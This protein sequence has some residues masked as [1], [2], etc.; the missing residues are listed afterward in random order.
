VVTSPRGLWKSQS[1]VRSREGSGSPSTVILSSCPTL[2]AGE[3]RVSP[4]R[5]TAALGDHGLRVAAGCDARPGDH[6]GDALLGRL[7]G[8]RAQRRRLGCS[9]RGGRA[10]RSSR[11]SKRGV[12]GRSSRPPARSAPKRPGGLPRSPWAA[13]RLVREVRATGGARA[14]AAGA[15][16]APVIA[17][18][19]ARLIAEPRWQS[20]DRIRRPG[21]HRPDGARTR[22]GPPC[23]FRR[24]S[25]GRRS[26]REGTVGSSR[27]DAIA[28]VQRT[29][30]PRMPRSRRSGQP[31]PLSA[32]SALPVAISMSRSSPARCA[33]RPSRSR[34]SGASI[35]APRTRRGSRRERRP[36][37]RGADLPPCSGDLWRAAGERGCG[38][39]ARFFRG[40]ALNL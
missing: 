1:R 29:I 14:R 6:L 20:E 36:V 4:F 39:A 11:R 22:G 38:I 23:G 31:L 30:R 33:P 37:L 2:T 35:M 12:R 32:T 16:S 13:T 21:P 8:F 19:H 9:F 7:C 27:L 28:L 17:V 5:V 40:A 24:R 34:A 3:A 18:C 10:G 25:S 15:F 26:C